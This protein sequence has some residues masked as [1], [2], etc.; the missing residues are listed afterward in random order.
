MFKIY[1]VN[2]HTHTHTHT[3]RGMHTHLYKYSHMHVTLTVTHAC[4]QTRPHMKIIKVKLVTVVEGDPKAPF[5]IATTPKC[6]R[7]HYSFLWI[8]PLYP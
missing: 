8:A 2:T 7:G 3:C 1:L 5:S 4:T 6:K